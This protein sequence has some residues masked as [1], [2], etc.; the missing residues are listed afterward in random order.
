MI[1]S[2]YKCSSI[3][4]FAQVIQH[5]SMFTHTLDRYKNDPE[6]FKRDFPYPPEYK[7]D[8]TGDEYNDE[9]YDEY[10]P[11]Y[12][13]EYGFDYPYPYFDH[14]TRMMLKD[15]YEKQFGDSSQRK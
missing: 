14:N 8:R 11:E 1:L 7:D 10:M 13:D 6:G 3:L 2:K 9:Y 12:L 4:K 15:E 5:R